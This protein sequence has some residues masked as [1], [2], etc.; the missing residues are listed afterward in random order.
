[1]SGEKLVDLERPRL[2]DDLKQHPHR[3]Q[4][5]P[6]FDPNDG[7]P[8]MTSAVTMSDSLAPA[9]EYETFICMGDERSFVIRDSWGQ[10][11]LSVHGSRARRFVDDRGEAWVA[12]LSQEEEAQAN[13]PEVFVGGAAFWFQVEPQRPQCEFYRRVMTD[14]E[15]NADM[16]QV[17]R[18]CAAQ[19][20]E[21]GEYVSL[22]DTRV[23]A[24][25][26]RS[27]PDF[28]SADRLRAFDE[29]RLRASQKQTEEFD[30][31]AA[32]AAESHGESK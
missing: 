32:L 18:V 12:Q 4:S 25:E 15:G 8:R 6:S 13:Y 21:G 1:M 5:A 10:I 28:V 24:C 11:L 27:P 22:R 20:T 17:E 29:A 7:L 3:I 16:R 31:E 19:R 14:F 23:Y 2:G 26:H 30:I 9:L